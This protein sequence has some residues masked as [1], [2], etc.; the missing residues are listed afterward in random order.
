M[1]AAIKAHTVVSFKEL[2]SLDSNK[3]Y[4]DERGDHYAQARYLCYYLQQHGL[5]AKFYREFHARQK[6]DPGGYIT[7]RRVL[8]PRVNMNVFQKQ[9]ETFVLGLKQGYEVSVTR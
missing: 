4:N 2:T 8:G 6:E 9:W 7:L 5:L 1:Q 3:F